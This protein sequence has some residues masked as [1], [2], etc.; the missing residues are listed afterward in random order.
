[1]SANIKTFGLGVFNKSPNVEY[2]VYENGLYLGNSTLSEHLLL[3][4]I[5][6]KEQTTF[7]LYPDTRTIAEFACY[8]SNMTEVTS[9]GN[10]LKT[11]GYGAFMQSKLTAITL[12]NSLE[13]IADSAFKQTKLTSLNFGTGLKAIG[14]EAFSNCPDL[15]DV[16]LP[17]SLERIDS[18]VFYGTSVTY[19][20]YENGR[21]LG[22]GDAG[23]TA[24]PY[25][26][27]MEVITKTMTTFTVHADTHLIV[28]GVFYGSSSLESVEIKEKVSFIGSGAF[29]NCI[30]LTSLS[31][32][33]NNTHFYS[34]SNKA[35][36]EKDTDRLLFGLNGGFIPEDTKI[37]GEKAF[38]YRK[39][40]EPL[41]I[42]SSVTTIEDYA[43][44]QTNLT[45]IVIPD[46]VTKIGKS[47]FQYSNSLTSVTL[48]KNLKVIED[49]TFSGCK[50]LETLTIPDSVTMIKEWA[51]S[52]CEML[53]NVTYSANLAFIGDVAFSSC[54]A[55]T[56]L[57]AS[58][59][60]RVFGSGSFRGC[61]SLTS[62]TIPK[63]VR[64]ISSGAFADCTALTTLNVVSEN[65]HY[66][67][68][69]NCNGIIET[70]TNTLMVAVKDTVIVESIEA[71]GAEVF[72]GID[73]QSITIPASITKIG[74]WAFSDCG[75]LETVVI[76]GEL[77]M[78]NAGTFSH[79]T[80]LTSVNIPETVTEIG[81]SA[82][83]N[84]KVLPEIKLPANL[85]KIGS[86]CF[87]RCTILPQI[88][89]PRSVTNIARSAFSSCANLTIYAEATALPDGWHA[90]WN[91]GNRPVY[92]YSET[93]NYDGSHWRYVDGVPT[94][95]AE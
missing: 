1:M 36:L 13:T 12:P 95:W 9:W 23:E 84:C 21:Y 81:G 76:E 61:E 63:N 87:G 44:Y 38:Y 30:A 52:N 94:V 67:S 33:A 86:W 49:W 31:V 41:V 28:P 75:K 53:A 92:W 83:Y 47:V 4:E 57:P 8:K 39:F 71:L 3:V 16:T 37:I 54:V 42:P 32:A 46:S 43:F 80:S 20:D 91:D 35:I 26:A 5:I 70:A 19:T 10:N 40:T 34:P 77:T 15:A 79:C 90:D 73:I 78:I 66:D 62:I 2:K 89:I 74:N 45:A 24:N 93:A 56:T 17:N 6:D 11:I 88:V 55:L 68:R 18:S 27:L 14:Y 59:S 25:F 82:F 48:S 60:L 65:N 69:E 50:I 7:K 85:E 51:F 58:E 29:E 22:S 72:S 64:Y